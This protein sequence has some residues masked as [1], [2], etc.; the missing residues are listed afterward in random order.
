MSNASQLPDWVSYLQALSTPA[1][2]IAGLAIAYQQWKI[3]RSQ[4]SYKIFDWRYKV[5]VL[6]VEFISD[7]YAKKDFLDSNV[8][9]YNL[10]ILEA[11]FIYNEDVYKFL[12]NISMAISFIRGCDNQM[13]KMS[14]HDA[15]RSGLIEMRSEHSKQLMEL[16]G[17]IERQFAPFLVI[18]DCKFR[19]TGCLEQF[20][21]FPIQVKQRATTCLHKMAD[22]C[23]FMPSAC[24]TWIGKFPVCIK[25][26]CGRFS[27]QLSQTRP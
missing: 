8:E 13:A 15:R 19:K 25:A 14:E 4:L 17:Q 24:F 10:I 23:H 7:Y 2:A 21:V 12:A 20:P 3:N 18:D 5:F 6:A 9:K 26:L 1:I 11:K 16:M 27:R 22:F